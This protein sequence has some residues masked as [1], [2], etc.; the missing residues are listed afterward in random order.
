MDDEQHIRAALAGV[1]NRIAEIAQACGRDPAEVSLLLATKTVPA[2]RVLVAM[3]AG[4]TLIG[5]NRVQ[6]LVAKADALAAVPHE[7]HVI[8][9]L[10]RNKVNQALRHADAIQSVDSRELA[11]AIADRVPAGRAPFDV[12][13]QVNTS[14]EESK[15]GATPG[16]AAA[17]AAYVGARPELRLRG[18]MT[19]GLFSTDAPAVRASY[20]RLREIRDAVLAAGAPGTEHARELSMGMSGDLDLAIAEGATMVRVGTAIF[21]TRPTPDSYYWPPS[22]T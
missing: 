16:D 3:R 19:I 1:R 14:G 11:D 10:Q 21:G 20:R 18:F 13:V 6:E 17:L 8:G 7:A 12:F 5:E 2:D 9:H 4:G 15:F 22:T